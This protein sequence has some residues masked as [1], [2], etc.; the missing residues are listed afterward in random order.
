MVKQDHFSAFRVRSP[1]PKKSPS[2]KD[3]DFFG[4]GDLV[5]WL[6]QWLFKG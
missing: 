2:L 3:G 1:A 6:K 4:A 5:K